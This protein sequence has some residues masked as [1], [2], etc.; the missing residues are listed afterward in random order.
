MI[1]VFVVYTDINSFQTTQSHSFQQIIKKIYCFDVTMQQLQKLD[2][3]KTI[4]Q[5][6]WL[7]DP[8]D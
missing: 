3:A 8:K 5:I 7:C 6:F 4:I 2:E 1:D